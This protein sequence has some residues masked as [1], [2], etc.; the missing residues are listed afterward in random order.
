MNFDEFIQTLDVANTTTFVDRDLSLGLELY[1]QLKQKLLDLGANELSSPYAEYLI[2][3]LINI[4]GAYKS[5]YRYHE[6]E[7]YFIE[8]EGLCSELIK[9][10]NFSPLVTS[11]DL[12]IKYNFAIIALDLGEIDK[13][14]LLLKEVENI[15]RKTPFSDKGI[16][17]QTLITIGLLFQKK[18][19]NFEKAQAYLHEALEVCQYLISA[20]KDMPYFSLISETLNQVCCDILCGLSYLYRCLGQLDKAIL[21]INKAVDVCRELGVYYED[22]SIDYLN[23]SKRITVITAHAHLYHEAEEFDNA[24]RDYENAE[25]LI[26][27]IEKKDKNA[28]INIGKIPIINIKIGKARVFQKLKKTKELIKTINQS[29]DVVCGGFFPP[30]I[31]NYF[32]Q[33]LEFIIEVYNYNIDNFGFIEAYED[34]FSI[35][36]IHIFNRINSILLIWYETQNAK[37]PTSLSESLYELWRDWMLFALETKDS[38]LLVNI[39]AAHHARRQIS[40]VNIGWLLSAENLGTDIQQFVSMRKKLLALELQLIQMEQAKE[41]NISLNSSLSPQYATL[42]EEYRT[43]QTAWL[44]SRSALIEQGRYPDIAMTHLSAEQLQQLLNE[45]EAVLLALSLR[46]FGVK[47]NPCFLFVSKTGID[48]IETPEINAAAEAM[49][50][51]TTLQTRQARRSNLR[52]SGLDAPDGDA[53]FDPDPDADE[54]LRQLQDN[55]SIIWR[56]LNPRLTAIKRLSIIGHGQFHTLP[57]QDSCPVQQNSY[58]PGLH[59]YLQRKKTMS[60]ALPMP[61]SACPVHVLAYAAEDKLEDR[62]YY[63]PAE[64]D[65]IRAVWSDAAVRV[66]TDLDEF[67]NVGYLFLLGHGNFDQ[68]TGNARFTLKDRHVEAHELLTLRPKLLGLGASA[69]LLGRTSDVSSEPLG[70]F[71][72]CANR[73][74]LQFSYGSILPVNDFSA[75][76]LSLHFHYQWRRQSSPHTAMRLALAALKSGQWPEETRE[77]F[78]TVM[79]R[80]M[81]V[82]FRALEDDSAAARG[83]KVIE[84]RIKNVKYQWMCNRGDYIRHYKAILDNRN[85]AEQ[86]QEAAVK[87]VEGLL[88][89]LLMQQPEANFG[90]FSPFWLYG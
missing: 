44:Y 45:N 16:F 11:S 21:V 54:V 53:F 79:V 12:N 85:S 56:K 37:M 1:Q 65:A 33:I 74:D 51:I 34:S 46:E 6:A 84:Q 71:S 50:I 20:H 72:L 36:V 29:I 26:D 9:S 64:I 2:T 27:D 82:L 89:R 88:E 90:D 80:Q 10:G 77:I 49:R 38:H 4:G 8:A 42:L 70:L 15:C 5:Y 62:L 57:W 68:E 35:D 22:G 87:L 31:F 66:I 41:F 14:K 75:L 55:M 58:F 30:N 67:S 7:R 63:I 78:I 13:A 24:I 19:G 43:I 17:M 76:L 39:V 23:V 81:P 59:V 60:L 28:S 18:E 86:K 83:N 61:S 3:T 69:C 52:H 48:Y 47:Y 32:S 73:P 40:I 25:S